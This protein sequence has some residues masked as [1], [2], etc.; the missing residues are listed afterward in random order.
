M[1]RHRSVMDAGWK[2]IELTP[3]LRI[4][5]PVELSRSNAV[6]I[7]SNASI[8][9][10]P[11]LT[12]VVDE[13]PF[14]DPLA[15]HGGRPIGQSAEETI[16]GRAARVVSSRLDDGSQFAGAHFDRDDRPGGGSQKLTVTVT[17]RD[18]DGGDIP[19]KVLRSLEFA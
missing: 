2:V 4:R 8:W 17:G 9:E 10:G 3:R 6:A 15:T 19:L 1:P 7:D 18:I 5:S 13:G 11:D 16:G 14:S 12:I